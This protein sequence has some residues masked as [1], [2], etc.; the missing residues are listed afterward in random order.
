MQNGR[1]VSSLYIFTLINNIDSGDFSGSSIG[2]IYQ[3]IWKQPD[4]ACMDTTK[5]CSV[6]LKSLLFINSKHFILKDL[7]VEWFM[8]SYRKICLQILG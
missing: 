7:R 2:L 6:I 3:C 8:N 1:G 5:I 4:I